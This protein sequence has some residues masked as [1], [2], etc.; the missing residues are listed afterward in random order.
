MSSCNF[1]PETG[2]IANAEFRSD[3]ASVPKVGDVFYVRTIPGRVGNGCG[4]GM[5]VHV[6]IVAPAGVSPAAP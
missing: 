4:T 6:E 3:P 2:I 1:D 5:S